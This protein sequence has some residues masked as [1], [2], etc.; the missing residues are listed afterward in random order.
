[1]T[2]RELEI[3]RF[4]KIEVSPEES[5]DRPFYYYTHDIV[6]GLSLIS[7]DSDTVKNDEWFVEFFNTEVPVR[8]YDMAQVL[9]LINLLTKAIVNEEKQ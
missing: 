4:Q 9:G 6:R 2:E 5:G 7:N 8:F 3:L 1:M